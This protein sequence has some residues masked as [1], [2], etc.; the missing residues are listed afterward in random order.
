MPPASRAM[1]ISDPKWTPDDARHTNNE[2]T[3]SRGN[4]MKP[5]LVTTKHR[6]VFA[7]QIADD[8]DITAL[9]SITPEAW[10]KWQTA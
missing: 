9:F 4:N 1:K 8:Q 2:P 5:V 7:G 10:R 3:T 6:G